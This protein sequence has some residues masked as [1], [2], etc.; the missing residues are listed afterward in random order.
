MPYNDVMDHINSRHQARSIVNRLVK[1]SHWRTLNSVLYADMH[2]RADVLC[3]SAND[4]TLRRLVEHA[5]MTTSAEMTSSAP[6]AAQLA[7]KM[8]SAGARPHSLALDGQEPALFGAMRITIVCNG[9]IAGL[10][11][12]RQTVMRK[13]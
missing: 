7:T 12:N 10:C 6:F 9:K 3:E 4:V 11:L 2:A 5:E 1:G 13:T 8:I